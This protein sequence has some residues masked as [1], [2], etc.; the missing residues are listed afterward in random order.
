MA[1]DKFLLWD[2]DGTLAHRPGQWSSTVLAVLHRAGLASGID[3]EAVRPFCNAGFPWHTPDRVR[4]AGQSADD[5]WRDLVPVLARAF[6][7][8][9]G[10]S[11]ERAT[12]LAWEVRRSYLEASAWVVFDDGTSC[13]PITSLNYRN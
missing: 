10:V 6:T 9:A 11:D 8:L 3:R 13:Y 1:L 12:E 5:W 2:F 7:G 4:E